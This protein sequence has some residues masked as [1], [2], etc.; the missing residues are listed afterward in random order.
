[1]KIIDK[2]QDKI[3]GI[4][5]GYD[6]MII[7]GHLRQFFS[8]SGKMY[9]LSQENVLL[10]DFGEYAK[11]ITGTIKEQVEK[12]AAERERPLVYLNSPKIAKEFTARD[13]LKKIPLR[14]D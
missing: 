1:M 4:L 5:S 13:I 10:K 6:R 8:P 2:F 11:R 9:F 3:K 12:L 14:E 7:K